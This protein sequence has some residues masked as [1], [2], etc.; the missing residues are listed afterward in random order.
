[1]FSM[2]AA[3]CPQEALAQ[4][5]VGLDLKEALYSDSG[6]RETRKSGLSKDKWSA[7]DVL[8]LSELSRVE[9]NVLCRQS[10]Y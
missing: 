2:S 1:M 7:C 10:Y 5:G 8:T 6:Q 4:E 9:W 3:A